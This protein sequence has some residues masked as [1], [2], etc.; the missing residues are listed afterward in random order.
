MPELRALDLPAGPAFVD[1]LRSAWEA[2]DAVL[3]LDRRLPPASAA[4]MLEALR[5]SVLVDRD[6]THRR[7]GGRPTEA[8]DALVVATSGTTGEPKGVVL[9]HAAVRASALAT[10]ARLDV[11]PGRDH[12]VAC[13]PLAH[14]GG[15]S[16]VTRALVTGTP[17][18]VLEG[19]DAAE[20]ARL[21]RSG[22]SL[23]S[24]VPTALGR[25][26]VSGYRAVLVGGSAPPAAPPPNVVTT[27]GQTETGSGVVY[28]GWPI[29]GAEVGLGDGRGRGGEDEILV[30]GPMVMCRYRDGSDP[31]LADGWLPTGDAGRIDPD[32]RLHVFGRRAE[33]IV[34]GGEKV[35]PAPVEQALARSPAVAEAAVWKRPDPEWGE[36]VVAYVV[37]ADPAAPP[38][39]PAL[40][41]LVSAEVAPWAAPR[42]LVLLGALPTTTGGKVVRHRLPPAEPARAA[43]P[44]L[45]WPEL[46]H[47][48]EWGP[49]WPEL[50][51]RRPRAAIR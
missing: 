7:H 29:D 18:T 6:G 36:R 25:T 21:G 35:W 9:T 48:P 45:N 32:G 44:G 17:C 8:G 10:S 46:R 28:D 37:A 16:V 38:E 49:I 20:V 13:L 1:A 12:W 39:L 34:T 27:Y 40:R 30:R 41:E 15:L 5:P 42:E 51:P 3:P 4:R 47:S 50:P 24:L 31:R 43:P 2:G 19:F 14:V 23:V 22:A 26:D 33:V 11:D